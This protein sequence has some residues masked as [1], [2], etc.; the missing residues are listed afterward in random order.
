VDEL[1]LLEQRGD[2]RVALVTLRSGL[3]RDADRV[4]VCKLEAQERMADRP[5]R[6]IGD[7]QIGADQLRQADFTFLVAWSEVVL[8]PVP[9]IAYVVEPQTIAVDDDRRHDRDI[10]PP[11]AFM[12]RSNQAPDQR[13]DA[14]YGDKC[15]DP[16]RRARRPQGPDAERREQDR[17]QRAQPDPWRR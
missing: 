17:K 4:C 10:G 15:G 16:S 3:D 12:G 13:Y 5:G 6:P 14:E 11:F 8:R 2:R 9:E 7:E 1:E